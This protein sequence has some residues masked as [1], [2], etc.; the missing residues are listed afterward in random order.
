M[1]GLRKIIQS[2]RLHVATDN[3]WSTFM[4]SVVVNGK[5]IEGGTSR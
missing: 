3:M 5:V 1:S 2:P 4:D